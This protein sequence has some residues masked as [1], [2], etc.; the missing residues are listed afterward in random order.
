MQGIFLIFA[1]VDARDIPDLFGNHVIGVVMCHDKEVAVSVDNVKALS[2]DDCEF[3]GELR[4]EV[5]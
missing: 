5:F 1:L 2:S 3:L 4:L